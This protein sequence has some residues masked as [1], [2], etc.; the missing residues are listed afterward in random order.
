MDVWTDGC[1]CTCVSPTK[2][3]LREFDTA[4]LLVRVVAAYRAEVCAAANAGVLGHTAAH[5]AN[6]AWGFDGR[7]RGDG[8]IVGCVFVV[9]VVLF[10]YNDD[11]ERFVLL[12]YVD[13]FLSPLARLSCLP[14]SLFLAAFLLG[15]AVHCR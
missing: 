2:L 10:F 9:F 3:L 14:A 11:L 1:I 8:Q 15:V 4:G 5:R 6:H 12:G 13:V 7:R